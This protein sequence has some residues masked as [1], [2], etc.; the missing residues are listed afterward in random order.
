MVPGLLPAQARI[1]Q[2]PVAKAFT[3]A[4][5]FPGMEEFP[6]VKVFLEGEA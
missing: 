5:V 2:I 3:Y 4:N 6:E 1:K